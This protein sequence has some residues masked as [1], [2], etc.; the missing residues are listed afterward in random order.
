MKAN[1]EKT[2][3]LIWIVVGLSI[4]SVIIFGMGLLLPP[5]GE[6]HASV[7]QGMGILTANITLVIFAYA[8]ASGKTATFKHGNTTATVGGS[9]KRKEPTE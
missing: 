4:V 3:P 6:V 5:A 2:H 1:K 9:R 7:L 8:I